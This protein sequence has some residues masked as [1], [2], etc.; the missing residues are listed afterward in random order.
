M[1]IKLKNNVVDVGGCIFICKNDPLSL[2]HS[3]KL[4]RKHRNV[5]KAWFLTLLNQANGNIQET[6]NVKMPCKILCTFIS[7]G[8][9]KVCNSCIGSKVCDIL[10]SPQTVNHLYFL[11]NHLEPEVYIFNRLGAQE[12]KRSL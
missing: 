12:R 7:E 5:F 6:F 10:G 9:L 1:L 2:T 8:A 4:I 11:S 3:Q